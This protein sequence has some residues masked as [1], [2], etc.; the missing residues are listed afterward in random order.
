MRISHCYPPWRHGTFPCLRPQI[1]FFL[2]TGSA[3]VVQDHWKA[4]VSDAATHPGVIN[5][6]NV[7][8]LRPAASILW[9][10]SGDLASL[11]CGRNLVRTAARCRHP[12]ENSRTC[13]W[14]RWR[15]HSP[16]PPGQQHGGGVRQ[17]RRVTLGAGHPALH[18]VYVERV[19]M[20]SC[21]DWVPVSGDTDG[22]ED[23]PP[24]SRYLPTPL[25]RC[26]RRK[27][28]CFSATL[29]SAS[30]KRRAV[31]PM[32]RATEGSEVSTGFAAE[33]SVASLTKI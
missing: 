6:R 10:T 31:T 18:V 7:E 5:T 22:S 29:Q 24:C 26:R 33:G 28:T 23:I 16:C 17:T 21:Q 14:P 8:A 32:R 15:Q 2:S 9:P 4:A 1:T 19:I 3:A 13:H 25:D 20:H 12:N 27:T 11:H 30:S